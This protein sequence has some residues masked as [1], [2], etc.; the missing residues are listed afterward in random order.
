VSGRGGEGAPAFAWLP[1]GGSA[2]A[3]AGDASARH[4]EDK[5]SGGPT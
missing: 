2:H 3:R 4:E 5:G 1:G